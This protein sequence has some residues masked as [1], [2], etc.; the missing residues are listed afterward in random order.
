MSKPRI[1]VV[2]RARWC[3]WTTLAAAALWAHS[4][5]DARAD[6][7]AAAGAALQ[8][9]QYHEV[10]GGAGGVIDVGLET[11]A[12]ARAHHLRLHVHAA[13]FPSEGAQLWLASLGAGWRWYPLETRGLN[14][15]LGTG[16]LLSYEHFELALATRRVESSR[17]R[18]GVPLT[19]AVGWTFWR[20]LEVAAA[21]KQVVF[22]G[23]G[24]RT[25]G[26]L[27]LTTGWRFR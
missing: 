18:F 9:L 3:R 19:A 26:Y 10:Y 25:I 17:V 21:W 5:A 2:I 15:G 23:E 6:V 8:V 22:F 4:P 1:L 14:V 24:T 27:T 12:W 20:Q 11:S 16:A 7:V 13:A